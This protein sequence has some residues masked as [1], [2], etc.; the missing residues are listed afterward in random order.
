[1]TPFA[2]PWSTPP[3]DQPTRAELAAD[4]LDDDELRDYHE[5]RAERLHLQAVARNNRRPPTNPFADELTEVEREA[6]W[7]Q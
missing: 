4:V 2:T 1:M 7:D 5:A 3:E 6:S